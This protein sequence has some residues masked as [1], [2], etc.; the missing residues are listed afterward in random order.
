MRCSDLAK[1]AAVTFIAGCAPVAAPPLDGS[2]RLAGIDG[3]PIAGT[4]NLQID[5]ATLSGH[6]PCNR[7]HAQNLSQWPQI[8]LTAIASTRRLCVQDGGEAA[9]LA[10][11]G[12]VET[13][14]RTRDVLTLSGPDHILRFT[15]E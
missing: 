12:Q 14:R 7:F 5:G 6:G 4:A 2:Y 10:A 11:L 9:F 3:A 15:A 13:A 1:L 8:D